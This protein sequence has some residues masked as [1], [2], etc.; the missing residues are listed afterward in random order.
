LPKQVTRDGEGQGARGG[1]R[2]AG[3]VCM[4]FWFLFSVVVGLRGALHVRKYQRPVRLCTF[5]F[6]KMASSAY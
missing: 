4:C 3:T 5:L 6:D 2:G 1:G